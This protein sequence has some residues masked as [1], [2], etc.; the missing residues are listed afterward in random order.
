[1]IRIERP[2]RWA[3]SMLSYRVMLDGREAG[4]IGHG[5]TLEHDAAPG[6]H[7][8]RLSADV[9]AI[10][11]CSSPTVAFEVPPAEAETQAEP[12][13]FRCVPAMAGWRQVFTVIYV[14]VLRGRCIR[15]ERVP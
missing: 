1:M 6:P 11:W 5:Q 4:R 14:T 7:E 15:L 8:L 9:L 3:D 13:T 12:I 2:S 10:G